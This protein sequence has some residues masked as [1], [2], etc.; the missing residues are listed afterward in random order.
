MRTLYDKFFTK[1]FPAMQDRLG[2]VFTPVPVVDYILH[3]AEAAMQRHFN[4]SLADEGVAIID[5]FLGTGTFVSRL[6]QSGIIPPEKLEQKYRNEI[7]ANEI[8]L[9]SYYIASI[10]IE[11][12]Y[13]EIRR[14]QG[15]EDEYVEFPG[16]T[17]TDTFQMR[18]EE[19]QLD[20]V[21]DFQTNVERVKRQREAPIRVI[22]MNPPY[23]VGQRSA[24]DNNQNLKYPNLDTRIEQ[25]YAARSTATNK[26]SLY[27]S[28]IRSLRW[29]SDRI[30]D[31]GVIA[32]VSNS[33]FIDGNTADGV[34]LT[35]QDEFSEIYICNLRGGIRG[36]IGEAAKREG[37]NVF[38]IM[39]GV[40][41]TILVKKKNQLGQA[42]IFYCEVGDYLSRQEKLNSLEANESI[43]S[44]SFDRIVPNTHGDWLNQRDDAYLE[45][46]ELGDAKT[47]GKPDTGGVFQLFSR[48]LETSRD[49]WCYNSSRKILTEN[50]LRLITNFNAE[51]AR[52][53]TSRT[54]NSD[55]SYVSW[56]RALK[57]DLDLHKTLRFHSEAP[58]TSMYRPFF[59]QVSYF[60]RRLN[61]YI[62]Q[63]QRIF[64]SPNHANIYCAVTGQ[65]SAKEFAV[66]QSDHLPD[67]HLLGAGVSTQIF[68]LFSWDPVQDDGS[69]FSLAESASSLDT[70]N[71]FSG[72]FDFSKPIAPQVPLEI[73]GYRRK[74]NIT[75]ATLADYRK[76]YQDVLNRDGE[77][78]TKE[79]IFFYVYA[80][81]HHPEY[82][83]KYEA[84]LKKML[85][86]IPKVAGFWEH[87]NIGRQLAELHVNYERL[88][89][90]PTVSE[91][92]SL[93]TPE[94][95]WKKYEVNK[96]EWGKLAGKRSKDFTTLIYNEY[97]TFKDIPAVANE[98]K[99]G[100]RSPLEWMVDRYRI[101]TDKKS[102]ITNDPNDYCREIGDPAYIADLVGKLV[103]VSM[104]TQELVRALPD[105]VIEEQ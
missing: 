34:R 78:I 102:G 19:D 56:T 2:I 24:N 51:I 67:L 95:E 48:G 41:I 35:W 87:S 101:T 13:H 91:D 64:P 23:S 103:T 80:L 105:L 49:A 18:E 50:V 76:H 74:D 61:E 63:L 9:L 57:K 29:S 86:R 1:A 66:Y 100:G 55:P 39:T 60:D 72:V 69:V 58:T 44:T 47:K 93:Y 5:P 33:S 6:L 82:R 88:E 10:N 28:Y 73:D 26:N 79:D 4:K 17:L 97:L 83:E 43:S 90:Y 75:D 31:E 46:Q 85:P 98:Y 38:P 65:G 12:V 20:V 15:F 89:S 27:D 25:T 62:N 81:L 30:G 53:A 92:W 16:I 40:A 84:D 37:D 14:E 32:F 3:S 22:V 8:V 11:Q 94:D 21:G 96:L 71:K 104:R 54:I 99:V 45:Y 68:S 36:K 42:K 52:G 77:R 70:A 7:F 59:K